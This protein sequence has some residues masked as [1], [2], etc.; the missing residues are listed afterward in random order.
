[1][2]TSRTISN[3]KSSGAADSAFFKNP[4]NFAS[5]SLFIFVTH[6][7]KQIRIVGN[8]TG[9]MGRRAAAEHTRPLRHTHVCGLRPP[10]PPPASRPAAAAGYPGTGS[11]CRSCARRRGV[12]GWGKGDVKVGGAE[13]ATVAAAAGA[14][15]DLPS[16]SIQS[17]RVS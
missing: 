5:I 8:S 1:M 10:S 17:T 13:T 12:V 3:S 6:S 9:L 2:V 15:E 11:P 14:E 16:S 4:C 7:Q